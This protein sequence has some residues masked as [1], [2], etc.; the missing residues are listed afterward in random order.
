MLIP[1]LGEG[2]GDISEDLWYRLTPTLISMK[3]K[4][5][6][7]KKWN[8]INGTSKCTSKLQEN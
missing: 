2:M 3:S 1:P 4:G 5:G 8:L 7:P 6:Y